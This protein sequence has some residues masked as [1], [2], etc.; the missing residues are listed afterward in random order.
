MII[1]VYLKN[2]IPL[3]LAQKKVTLATSLKNRPIECLIYFKS[4]SNYMGQD[5][6]FSIED[7]L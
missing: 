4:T 6:Y 1:T 7:I 3:R 5:L 2:S